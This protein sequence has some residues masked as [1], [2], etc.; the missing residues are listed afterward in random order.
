VE[1]AD[2]ELGVSDAKAGDFV[3]FDP[4]YTTAHE[5][6]GFIEYN[7]EVFAWRDQYR[8]AELGGSLIVRGI[9]VVISNA[10]HSS[11]TRVYRKHGF[12]R[13]VID[14][15]STIAGSAEKRF[16]TREQVFVG[17]PAYEGVVP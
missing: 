15:V 7:A 3:Y 14:R 5:N 11:I 6:N 1:V 17:G 12:H 16:R 4:P 2:F 8:L 10:F 9:N 13:H